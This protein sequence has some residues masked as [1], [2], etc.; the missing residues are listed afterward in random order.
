[1][2]TP[3]FNLGRRYYTRQRMQ[4]QTK[5]EGYR[6][7]GGKSTP[8][9]SN[10]RRPGANG[11]IFCYLRRLPKAYKDFLAANFNRVATYPGIGILHRFSRCHIE[12]PTMPRASHH[13]ALQLPF[14]QR[15]ASV[16]AGA[17][18]RVHCPGDV[19]QC[20]CLSLHLHFLDRPRRNFS[21]CCCPL[22]SHS[23]PNDDSFRTAAS[24]FSVS[25]GSITLS[26]G[27][28]KKRKLTAI[29]AAFIPSE[30]RNLSSIAASSMARTTRAGSV[31]LGNVHAITPG[32]FRF[33][34]HFVRFAYQRVKVFEVTALAACNSKCR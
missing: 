2:Q 4:N 33:V 23:S 11:F 15:T 26:P 13:L 27:M 7:S 16:Q 29:R 14:S 10:Q 3:A 5:C 19:G 32:A 34:K 31:Q 22:K 17:A 24:P 18:D 9:R 21:K 20:D 25:P 1:L 8:R 12:L 30:V 6:N 28:V